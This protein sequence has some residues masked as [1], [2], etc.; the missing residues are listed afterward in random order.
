MQ[1]P[2]RVGLLAICALLAGACEGA[3]GGSDGGSPRDAG[4]RP[5]A[6]AQIDAA[7]PT[8]AAVSSDAAM[9]SDGGSPSDAGPR[10]DEAMVRELVS[11]LLFTSESDY[12]IEVLSAA[13]EGAAAP[14]PETVARVVGASPEATIES[15]TEARFW[16]RVVVDP[17]VFVPVPETQPAALRAAFEALASDRIVVRAIEPDAPAEVHVFL[18]GRTACGDLVALASISIET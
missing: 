2:G 6:S 18:V 1:R 17:T 12:P 16:A 9:P 11:G 8:D 13:G 5:D 10:C 15:D 7:G 3:I 14:T 4:S